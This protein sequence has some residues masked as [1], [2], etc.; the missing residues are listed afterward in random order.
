MIYEPLED[1]FLIKEEIK[2]YAKNNTVLD[3]GTGSGIQALEAVKY[4]K[5]VV[6]ADINNEA[7]KALKKIIKDKNLKKIKVIKSDLFNNIKNKFNLIIFN[8]PYL[9]LDESE[10][11]DSRLAT[12]GG[13]KGYELIERFLNDINEYLEPNG[14]LLLLFSSLTNKSKVEEFITNNE[15]EFKQIA[16]QKLFFEVLYVYEVR[17][18]KFNEIIHKKCVNK[19]KKFTH[20]HRGNIYIGNLKST[21][22]A[23][24]KQREDIDAFNT[25]NREIK[26]LK[27]LNK[28]NIGPKFIFGGNNYFCYKFIEGQFIEEF[29]E[30]NKK[31]NIKK[32]LLDIF[33]QCFI[34]DK[35]GI[36]KEEMHNPYKH[37]II[38]KKNKAW[39]IDFERSNYTERPKNITQFIQYIC[40]LKKDLEDKKFKINV[41]ILRK[42]AKSYKNNINQANYNRIIK[43]I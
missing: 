10:P 15:L 27:L 9:P 38:D 6:A 4:A 26:F 42:L 14:R 43:E 5:S 3:M 33:K 16:E 18:T 28:K 23:I 8:P 36:N 21:K 1:S 17:K 31:T 24:K 37:I 2:R 25:V 7:V 11:E 30:K 12:T 41:D 40:H 20:G 34:M 19:L 13:K 22:I 29:I 35:L 39:F 32:V